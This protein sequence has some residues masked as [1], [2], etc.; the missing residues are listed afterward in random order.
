MATS[1]TS[2]NCLA[3]CTCS[4]SASEI[5]KPLLL[6]QSAAPA[7]PQTIEDPAAIALAHSIL[8]VSL[9]HMGDLGGARVELEAARR[10]WSAL[11]GGPARSISASI[12]TIGRRHPGAKLCG[13]KVIRPRPWNG[14][15]RPSRRPHAWTIRQLTLSIALNCA[16]TCSFGGRSRERRRAHGL[17]DLPCRIP[18]ADDLSCG[19]TRLQRRSWRSVEATQKAGSRACSAALQRTPRR[20]VTSCWPL[21]Q[22]L[23]RRRTCSTGRFAARHRPDRRDDRTGPGRPGAAVTCRSC[24]G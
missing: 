16:V 22:H 5:S 17:A 1:S 3:C 11:P 8:G 21:V 12:A 13:C 18:F 2:C 20:C 24:C 6:T 7:C 23:A 19:R 15:T 10:A 4:T 14:P 9:H